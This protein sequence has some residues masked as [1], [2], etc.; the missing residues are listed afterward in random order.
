M[1]SWFE[2][3][4]YLNERYSIFKTCQHLLR[5]NRFIQALVPVFGAVIARRLYH[6][7]YRK[8][9]K[10]PPG[11]IGYP[12]LGSF[13]SFASDPFYPLKMSQKYGGIVSIPFTVGYFIVLSDV[14][15]V[16]ELL[17]QKE[18]LNRRNV[19]TQGEWKSIYSVSTN[20]D[21]QTY[22][23]FFESGESWTK[24]RQHATSVCIYG[25]CCVL[26]VATA[27]HSQINKT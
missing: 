2:G 17:P 26:L 10:L 14:K 1:E 6:V 8:W 25:I 7:I 11:P 9:N 12:L 13:L 16:K 27:L 15:L 5:K 21:H 18:Y 22:P 4:T 23:F 24:R 20:T 3:F 19:L